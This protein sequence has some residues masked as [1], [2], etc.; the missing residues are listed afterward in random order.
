MRSAPALNRSTTSHALR[1]GRMSLS[2]P[3]VQKHGR[4]ALLITRSYQADSMV[5]LCGMT[6]PDGP[7]PTTMLEKL[8][9]ALKTGLPLAI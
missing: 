4:A 1:Q 3:S 8:M 7:Q 2:R 5:P 9:G 6:K